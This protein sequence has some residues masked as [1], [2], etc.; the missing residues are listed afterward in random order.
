MW[1]TIQ[2]ARLYGEWIYDQS[3]LKWHTGGT[4]H[5]GVFTTP[6]ARSQLIRSDT[7]ARRDSSS[8][9]STPEATLPG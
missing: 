7:D 1:G 4:V 2:A 9:R 5:G 8:S 3:D 6:R